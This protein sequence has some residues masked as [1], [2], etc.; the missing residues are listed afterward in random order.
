ML[1]LF[2]I[3]HTLFWIV[4]AQECELSGSKWSSPRQS[5]GPPCSSGIASQRSVP[6]QRQSLRS[7]MK[8]LWKNVSSCIALFIFIACRKIN[9]KW[10]LVENVKNEPSTHLNNFFHI[11]VVPRSSVS[12]K[13]RSS[14]RRTWQK[15]AGTSVKH[16]P[17]VPC[18]L[19]RNS[20]EILSYAHCHTFLHVANVMMYHDVSWCIMMYLYD[21][22]R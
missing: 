1:I 3:F 19:G 18:R 2:H 15:L 20:I 13:S 7:Y 5:V 12:T 4:L 17:R 6:R 16:V 21:S 10:V 22:H 14:Q 8:K 9:R 11:E